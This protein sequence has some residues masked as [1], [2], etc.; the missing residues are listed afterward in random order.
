MRSI[1]SCKLNFRVYTIHIAFTKFPLLFRKFLINKIRSVNHFTQCDNLR[2]GNGR[3]LHF[4]S[5][6]RHFYHTAI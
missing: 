2:S 4:L 1:I 3:E 6:A 5:P